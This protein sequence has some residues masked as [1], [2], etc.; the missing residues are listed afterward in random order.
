MIG[1]DLDQKIGLQPLIVTWKKGESTDRREI[2][3]EVVSASFGTETLKLPKA[4]VDLDPPHT[5]AG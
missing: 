3:I 5:R 2:P 4:M 1:I